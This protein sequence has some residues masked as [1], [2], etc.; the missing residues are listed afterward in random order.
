MNDHANLIA[1]SE[2]VLPDSITIFEMLANTLDARQTGMCLC[3]PNDCV[4]SWN[5]TFAQ[6]FAEM[7]EVLLPG[8]KFQ[9]CLSKFFQ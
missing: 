5:Q 4:I 9:D 8:V 2:I 3:D 6:V 1:Q 7:S